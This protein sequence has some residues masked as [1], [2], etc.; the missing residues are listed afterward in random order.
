MPFILN[1]KLNLLYY[2]SVSEHDVLWSS[3][4]FDGLPWKLEREKERNTFVCL[5]TLSYILSTFLWKKSVTERRDKT[6]FLEIGHSTM[7]IFGKMEDINDWC[8][9]LFILR[10]WMS[11][12][13]GVWAIWNLDQPV[14]PAQMRHKSER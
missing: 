10:T 6:I 14:Y 7:Y 8:W 3:I 4:S 2:C 5:T 13:R 11:L 1:Y 12:T 9:L